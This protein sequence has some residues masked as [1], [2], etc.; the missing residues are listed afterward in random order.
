MEENN[1]S[2]SSQENAPNGNINTQQPPHNQQ[3]Y[4]G[5]AQPIY[6]NVPQKNNLGLAGFILSII[7]IV[8]CWIPFLGQILW[9]LG[10][11]F[12]AIGIFKNPRGFA[13]AGLVISFIGFIILI[14]L[15][16]LIGMGGAAAAMS[17]G[18]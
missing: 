6:V 2:F 13:I 8:L 12:S 4:Q 10:V 5:Y 7:A 18:Y 14:I 16:G 9:L 15:L 1:Q 17:S 3:N 11:V